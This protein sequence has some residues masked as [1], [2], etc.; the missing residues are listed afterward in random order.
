MGAF[1]L[2]VE[3]AARDIRSLLTLHR[4]HPQ[5]QSDIQRVLGSLLRKSYE[6]DAVPVATSVREPPEQVC[7]ALMDTI[8]ENTFKTALPA[9]DMR[10]LE[11]RCIEL[12]HDNAGWKAAADDA[13]KR[14]VKVQEV[15]SDLKKAHDYMLHSYFREVLMLRCRID[16]LQRQ[17]R[18]RRVYATSVAPVFGCRGASFMPTMESQL[19]Q[20]C[21]NT[22]AATG[23]S[24]P[25][26]R[27]STSGLTLVSYTPPPPCGSSDEDTEADDDF[28]HRRLSTHS[29]S[30]GEGRE[31]DARAPA[32]IFSASAATGSAAPGVLADGKGLSTAPRRRLKSRNVRIT[33]PGNTP[34]HPA[35]S[36]SPH[37]IAVE[38]TTTL[39]L[40]RMPE[41]D[42]VDA[43][44]DYEEYVRILNGEDGAWAERFA[45]AMD[46]AGRRSA[47]RLCRS[48]RVRTRSRSEVY[49]LDGSG[50]SSP[51][52]HLYNPLVTAALSRDRAK[53]NGFHWL[54]HLALE[55]IK[56]GFQ[57]EL[58]QLRQ[59]VQAMQREHA[60]QIQLIQRALLI[61]QSRNEALLDFLSTFAEQALHT[62]SVVACDVQAQ[63]MVDILSD[64][65]LPV[66]AAEAVATFF[67]TAA[68]AAASHEQPSASS[69][70]ASPPHTPSPSL[71]PHEESGQE[72]TMPRLLRTRRWRL[73][74]GVALQSQEQA[75][76]MT[77][78]DHR[79]GRS[80]AAKV[81][82]SMPNG[83]ANSAEEINY[84]RA[85]LGLPY[86]G[87][88]P[89]ISHAQGI[90]GKLQEVAG[91]IRAT[92]VKQLVE[93]GE[94]AVSDDRHVRWKGKGITASSRLEGVHHGRNSPPPLS[95][96][97]GNCAF[98]YFRDGGV[99][100]DST[101]GHFAA[102]RRLRDGWRTAPVSGADGQTAADLLRELA[103]LRMRRA[104]DRKRLELAQ[105]SQ[106]GAAAAI[107]ERADRA[108]RK[109]GAAA[110]ATDAEGE[111]SHPHFSSPQE[112]LRA[113][114]LQ[115]LHTRTQARLSRTSQRIA[116]LQRLLDLHLVS[117][118]AHSFGGSLSREMKWGIVAEQSLRLLRSSGTLSP[119]GHLWSSPYLNDVA[120]DANDQRQL[121]GG[122]YRGP[123]R[124]QLMHL[125]TEMARAPNADGNSVGEAGA[126]FTLDGY[127]FSATPVA[128]PLTGADKGGADSGR[129]TGPSSTAHR[130]TPFVAVMDYCRGVQLG[131]PL[132]RRAGPVYLFQDHESGDYYVGDEAGRNV[133]GPGDAAGDAEVHM[134]AGAHAQR[135]L[136]PMSRILYPAPMNSVLKTTTSDDSSVAPSDAA[137][138]SLHP[139]YL[140]PMA[141]PLSDE[142]AVVREGWQACHRHGHTRRDPIYYMTMAPLPLS[143]SY[144]HIVPPPGS[145]DAVALAE[146]DA[147]ACNGDGDAPANRYLFSPPRVFQPADE[148]AAM[149]R[150][151]S[152]PLQQ[153]QASNPLFLGAAA[154]DSD[155][156]CPSTSFPSLGFTATSTAT[157]TATVPPSVNPL[158]GNAISHT[159]GHRLVATPSFA[160][161]RREGRGTTAVALLPGSSSSLTAKSLTLS[162]S[163][164]LK[165]MPTAT[166][167]DSAPAIAKAVLPASAAA[168]AAA[169]VSSATGSSPRL[170]AA[171]ILAKETRSTRLAEEAARA[172]Q[173]RVL[174]PASLRSRA[175]TRTAPNKEDDMP[176]L[177]PNRLAPLSSTHMSGGAL[178]MLPLPAHSARL[179]RQMRPEKYSL[180]PSLSSRQRKAS[181]GGIDIWNLDGDDGDGDAA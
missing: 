124:G 145:P 2:C 122:A 66:A 71:P 128:L 47:R 158:S 67:T 173:T 22:N 6:S 116:E 152:V 105:E 164:G 113:R 135:S 9:S 108:K 32:S 83:P 81:A 46:G 60:G 148:A 34:S 167:R 163:P 154:M 19:Q 144:H 56:H 5:V 168:A 8:V 160:A 120:L 156:A 162:S 28:A 118:Q 70:A 37:T 40:L 76:A 85:D 129:E 36:A 110:G 134:R 72:S 38:S 157:T 68:S 161:D 78:M 147:A 132:G 97:G 73:K 119:A 3:S 24:E 55:P 42:S 63:S 171:L 121:R 69:M 169:P 88:N 102:Y 150:V 13:D 26:S 180:A 50:S 178:S 179:Q 117:C 27:Q 31:G 14:V 107:G 98:H 177:P 45:D 94:G 87:S 99:E 96:E 159:Q 41:T 106:K 151:R 103:G 29:S 112:A 141:I 61:V 21:F 176:R 11:R 44:F 51:T 59:T 109:T 62:L 75:A 58:D 39:E 131:R 95:D 16:D 90:F 101:S 93:S 153:R 136:L 89:V 4:V 82:H 49:F 86:W 53:A 149:L 12:E 181:G 92:R 115:Q 35:T 155:S 138:A 80:G 130:I 65:A 54:L 43:I 33:F 15:L 52:A 18:T 25:A 137:I 172:A 142:D 48:I 123:S 23:Q 139:T 104:C 126:F 79:L 146:M 7:R 166:S 174:C 133:L 175:V 127:T 165:V 111:G 170:T 125:P 114:A 10:A 1:A 140:V 64:G 77:A 30:P 17:L 143:K 100:E 20:F 74:P 91:R 57:I 84:Y